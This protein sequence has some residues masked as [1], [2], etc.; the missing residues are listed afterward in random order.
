MEKLYTVSK[1]RLGADCGSDYQL[2][3]AKFRLTLEK[4]GKTSRPVRYDLNHIP[5]EY[6][7]EVTNRFKRLDLVNRVPEEPWKEI[8]NIIAQEE[9]KKKSQR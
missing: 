6:T 7:V 9:V 2:L 5:Y 4:A 1:Q 8:H 3:I